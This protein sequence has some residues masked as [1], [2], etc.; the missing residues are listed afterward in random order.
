MVLPFHSRVEILDWSNR[1]TLPQGEAV[2]LHQ[3]AR[4]AQLWYGSHADPGWHKWTVAEAQSIFHRAGLTADFWNLG[5]H[6][7]KF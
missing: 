1:H 7:G 4:L 3:V 5:G 2:P 6:R